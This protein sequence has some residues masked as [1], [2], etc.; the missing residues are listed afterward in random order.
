MQYKFANVWTRG[1]INQIEF[2]KCLV[3]FIYSPAYLDPSW[4]EA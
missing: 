2:K 1:G 3:G 4:A